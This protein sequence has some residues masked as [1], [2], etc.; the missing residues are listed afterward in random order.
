MAYN[1]ASERQ[2]VV[3]S[4]GL[5]FAHAYCRFNS[6]DTFSEVAH[7][8]KRSNNKSYTYSNIYLIISLL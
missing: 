5:L 2:T 3:E 4:D 6:A 1:K 8:I 7:I